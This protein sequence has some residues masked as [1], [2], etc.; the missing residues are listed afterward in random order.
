MIEDENQLIFTVDKDCKW[1]IID[2]ADLL[3]AVYNL[4]SSDYKEEYDNLGQQYV[5]NLRKKI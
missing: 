5:S 1:N 4:S 2:L 3:D